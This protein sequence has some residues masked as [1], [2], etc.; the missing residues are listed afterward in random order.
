MPDQILYFAYG[1][2]LDPDRI[3]EA[4]PGSRFLFTAHFPET[5]LGFVDHAGNGL[6]PTLTRKEGHTVWGGVFEIPDDAVDSL[7][8]AEKAEGR[9]PG[10]DQ[11]AVD[12]EGHKYRCLTFVADGEPDDE[13]RPSP[14]H[15]EAMIRG[16]RHWSLPAGWVMGLEDLTEDLPFS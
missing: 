2:L 6:I 15:L 5:K 13:A 3:A 16:A 8:R 12:R 7:I 14:E 9:Q 11:K 4:A 1:S 10:F